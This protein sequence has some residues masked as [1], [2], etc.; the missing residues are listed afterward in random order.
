MIPTNL[1]GIFSAITSALVWGSGDFTGGFASRKGNSL[2]V[3]VVSALSGLAILVLGALVMRE[4]L[5]SLGSALWAFSAG[6]LGTVGVTALYFGLSRQNAA[7]VAP[8]SAVLGAA[9]PVVYNTLAEGAPQ[10]IRLF[11][12]G[13]ALLGIWLVS[14][15]E[16]GGLHLN[17]QGLGLGLLAGL[18]FGCF[19][20]L[21]AQVEHGLI[22]T[23]LVVS[24]SV[25][26]LASFLLLRLK[27]FHLPGLRHNRLALLAGV[28]D[29]GGNFFFLLARQWI[30]LDV[31]VVL[32]SLFPAVTV[33]LAFFLQ[34]Q[35]IS[36]GQ[37]L[38]VGVCVAAIVMITA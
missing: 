36:T 23:P 32:S 4:R 10:V 26:F 18:G 2:Q 13:L 16:Q 11:G 24:R 22:F 12:F 30:R 29:A 28:L 6:L 27:G 31:A 33:L 14:Q 37:W 3:V 20:I 19:F 38:G 35:K 17:R 5:P 8:V 25:T 7:S 15:S 9:L 21:I 1:L 34:K